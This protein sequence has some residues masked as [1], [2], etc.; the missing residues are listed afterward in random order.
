VPFARSAMRYPPR[1]TSSASADSLVVTMETDNSASERN[2][3]QDAVDVA[4]CG[5]SLERNLGGAARRT[6]ASGRVVPTP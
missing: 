5:F 6:P 1:W 3:L 2:G 4:D